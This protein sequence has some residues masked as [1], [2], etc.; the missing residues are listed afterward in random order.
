MKKLLLT[1]TALCIVL[2]ANAQPTFQMPKIPTAADATLNIDLWQDGLPN[3]NGIDSQ[4]WDDEAR[5]FKPSISVFLPEEANRNGMAVLI[6]PGGGY[7]VLSNSHEAYLW[8]DFFTSQGIAAVVLSYRMPNGVTEVP[9]SDA[10]EALRVIRANAAEWGVDP[11]KVGIMGSSAGGHLAST[12][13]THSPV[14]T[15][16]A[17]QILCYPVISMDKEY[18]HLDSHNC[19]IGEDASPELEALY[20][21]QLQVDAQT[22][23]AILLLADDDS[24]VPARNSAEYYLA[25]KKAGVKANIHVYPYGGHGFGFGPW[26]K[27]HDQMVADL[28]A[29]IDALYAPAPKWPF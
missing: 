23:P 26:F 1:L 4:P 18:T 15:R 7:R 11:A 14:E 25:L 6:C 24:L 17:F 10:T 28:Q 5:N 3:S 8:T 12:V 27:F 9:I 20:S 21:N 22:P 13:A 19:I 29:W 2:A 16:P